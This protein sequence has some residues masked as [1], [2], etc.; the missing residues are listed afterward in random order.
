MK[1]PVFVV[2]KLVKK[3]LTVTKKNDQKDVWLTH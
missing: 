2:K 3:C 1:N